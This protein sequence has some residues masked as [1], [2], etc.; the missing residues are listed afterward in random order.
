MQ[1]PRKAPTDNA[2]PKK[3]LVSLPA[4]AEA[5]AICTV[6]AIDQGCPH[7]QVVENVEIVHLEEGHPTCTVK[8]GWIGR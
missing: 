5:V 7:L 6:T 2:Q 8:I 4:I 1:R 3:P